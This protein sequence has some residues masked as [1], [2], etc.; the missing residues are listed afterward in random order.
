MFVP[1][2]MYAALS[3]DGTLAEYLRGGGYQLSKVKRVADAATSR[4]LEKLPVLIN[5]LKST[6]PLFRYWG[7]MGCVIL[8]EKVGVAGKYLEKV[9]DDENAAVRVTAA[10]ALGKLGKKELALRVLRKEIDSDKQ[11]ELLIALHALEDFPDDWKRFQSRLREIAGKG[12]G[13]NPS[14]VAAWM[15][16]QM[17]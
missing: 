3:Q 1:E 6:D 8:G 10:H 4:D 14:R 11:Y 12:K 5:A 15:L 16:E 7:A 9:L 13:G 2:A 17:G